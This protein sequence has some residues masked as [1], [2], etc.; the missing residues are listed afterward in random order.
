VVALPGETVEVQAGHVFI[1]GAAIEEPWVENFGGPD[2]TRKEIPAGHVFIL[3]D[4]RGSSLD[5][6]AIGPVSVDDIKGRAWVVY[7]PFEEI[8]LIP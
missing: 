5:S 4:N 6:R 1:N 8:Q 3:G 2:Y 7:W